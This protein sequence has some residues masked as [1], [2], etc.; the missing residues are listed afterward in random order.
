[1]L[2]YFCAVAHYILGAEVE[3]SVLFFSCSKREADYV[4]GCLMSKFYGNG[5]RMLGGLYHPIT[6]Q[7]VEYYAS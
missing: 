6:H 2:N 4:D 5:C 1:M 3:Q 7:L